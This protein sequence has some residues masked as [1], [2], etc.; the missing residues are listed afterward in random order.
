MKQDETNGSSPVSAKQKTGKL[1]FESFCGIK[2][3]RNYV[4]NLCGSKGKQNFA[5]TKQKT[6]EILFRIVSRNKELEFCYE[7]LKNEKLLLKNVS[8][9]FA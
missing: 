9:L 8:F 7:S 2:N 6:G 4:R 5:S 3:N 1:R